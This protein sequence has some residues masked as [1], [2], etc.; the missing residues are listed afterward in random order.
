MSTKKVAW[1]LQKNLYSQIANDKS[2]ILLAFKKPNQIVKKDPIGFF[3]SKRILSGILQREN[4]GCWRTFI[5]WAIIGQETSTLVRV[6]PKQ[7]SSAA[8]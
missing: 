6:H 7:Y 1:Q 4:R 5:L 2:E 3:H 8:D